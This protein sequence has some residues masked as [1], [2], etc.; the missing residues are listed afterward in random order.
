MILA[1]RSVI[2][3]VENMT[4]DDD[5]ADERTRWAVMRGYEILGEAVRH[6]PP[7]L[8]AANPDIPWTTM[9]A[10]RNQV[11]HGYFGIQDSIL[12]TTIEEDVK[13]LLPLLEALAGAHGVTV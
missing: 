6:I 9:S 13:P 10:V 8:K 1:C 5:L 3:F 12:F 7:E 11:V 4:L 2:G